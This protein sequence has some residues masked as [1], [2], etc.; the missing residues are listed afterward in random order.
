MVIEPFNKVINLLSIPCVQFAQTNSLRNNMR[1]LKP[2]HILY[3]QGTFIDRFH[4]ES[5][6]N[7][8]SPCYYHVKLVCRIHMGQDIFEII[9]FEAFLCVR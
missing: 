6:I 8:I 5:P 9:F 3:V 7:A 1:N 4:L 2:Q